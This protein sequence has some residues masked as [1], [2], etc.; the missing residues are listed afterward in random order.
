MKTEMLFGAIT[1]LIIVTTVGVMAYKHDRDINKSQE[2]IN[3]KDK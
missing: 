1:L 3:E 2:E